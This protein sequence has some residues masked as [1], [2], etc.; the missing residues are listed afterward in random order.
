MSM[1]IHPLVDLVNIL[2]IVYK[3]TADRSHFGKV[4]K[5][6][7][8]AEELYHYRKMV[9]PRILTLSRTGGYGFVCNLQDAYSLSNLRNRIDM[10][11]QRLA[12]F[13]P[14]DKKYLAGIPIQ[15][16]S[17]LSYTLKEMRYGEIPREL[18]YTTLDKENK[19]QAMS[20]AIINDSMETKYEEALLVLDYAEND[21]IFDTVLKA[22]IDQLVQKKCALNALELL[23]QV[24][25]HTNPKARP[26]ETAL[27]RQVIKQTKNGTL[28]ESQSFLDHIRCLSRLGQLLGEL[29]QTDQALELIKEMNTAM[30][31]Q[32]FDPPYQERPLPLLKSRPISNSLMQELEEEIPSL[33]S[34][35]EYPALFPFEESVP[36]HK[37]PDSDCCGK[38]IHSAVSENRSSLA[39]GRGSNRKY[40]EE[41][42]KSDDSKKDNTPPL[43]YYLNN[44]FPLL[45][46][47]RDDQS[48]P[49]AGL[50]R[51]IQETPNGDQRDALL[52]A[53]YNQIM[54]TD[55]LYE[56]LEKIDAIEDLTERDSILNW[57]ADKF[58]WT[59]YDPERDQL[60]F[61]AILSR[62]TDPAIVARYFC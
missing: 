32:T 49:T 50:L 41:A 16:A 21:C 9:K 4:S 14:P 20:H 28:M 12:G 37:T 7:K 62:I 1:Q 13:L 55:N 3:H 24:I 38:G 40:W 53:L 18:D 2:A 60:K 34:P 57:I 11:V 54:F 35:R 26:S 29:G 44:P 19:I 58:R 42:D 22:A 31:A 43:S 52:D 6:W 56:E 33:A 30:Q 5:I 17:P 46:Y 25:C 61:E 15:L 59:N 51:K 27:F 10:Y 48:L 39:Q 47:E 8:E 36:L 45:S 23:E